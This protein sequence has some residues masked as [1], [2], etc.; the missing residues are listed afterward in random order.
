VR[1]DGVGRVSAR[2]SAAGV[3]PLQ[4]HME[5]SLQYLR[6][7]NNKQ[8]MSFLGNF[9]TRFLHKAALVLKPLMVSLKSSAAKVW[10]EDMEAAFVAA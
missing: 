10:C 1:N 3:V 9:Y 6:P 2:V 5:A 7:R 8:L 4:S